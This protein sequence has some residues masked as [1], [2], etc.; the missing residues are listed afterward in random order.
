ML[1]GRNGGNGRPRGCNARER[2]GGEKK[3]QGEE[4]DATQ[5]FLSSLFVS[6]SLSHQDDVI[7]RDASRA[8][9]FGG[10]SEADL[11]SDVDSRVPC[12]KTATELQQELKQLFD[13]VKGG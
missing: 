3:N 7:D 10:V 13:V 12:E 4:D 8:E 6:F 1:V 5:F 2:K 11:I 9:I